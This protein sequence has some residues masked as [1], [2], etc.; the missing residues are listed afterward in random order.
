M[1][2]AIAFA[3]LGAGVSFFGGL[4]AAKSARRIAKMNADLAL[5]EGEVNAV[6]HRKEVRSLLG[7]QRSAY[8]KGGVLTTEGTA[9][10]VTR[11]TAIQ[12][13]QDALRIKYDAYM[14]ARIIKAG[15]T[16][17]SNAY[18]S[19]AVGGLFNSAGSIIGGMG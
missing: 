11:D 14:R 18:I 19:Q 3:A 5:W 6:R 16:A 12:G 8:A 4:S 7:T 9:A 1:S 13:E 10:D 2:G 17:Q 15:G